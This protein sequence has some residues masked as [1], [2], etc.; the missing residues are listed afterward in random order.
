[1]PQSREG[2]TQ[3]ADFKLEVGGTAQSFKDQD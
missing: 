1:M 2:E 3:D